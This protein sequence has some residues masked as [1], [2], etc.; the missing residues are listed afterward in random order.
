M[1][2]MHTYRPAKV[3][4]MFVDGLNYN[5]T[6]RAREL[7]SA[8]RKAHAARIAHR[9][10]KRHQID[11]HTAVPLSAEQ[12][13][14]AWKEEVSEDSQY[15]VTVRKKKC[16]GE[17][18]S[19]L[20]EG[21]SDPFDCLAIVVTPQINKVMT[22][23]R[24]VVIPSIF[25]TP[26]FRR[27]AKGVQSEPTVM[28]DSRV[29]SS[30]GAIRDWNLVKNSLQD[31][32]DAVSCIAGLLGLM[33]QLS[34]ES[35]GRNHL[36]AIKMQGRAAELLRHT[37]TRRN[38]DDLDSEMQLAWRV[39]WLFRGE[40][41]LGDVEAAR[42]HCKMLRHLTEHG[43]QHGTF[44]IQFLVSVLFNDVDL[45]A[46]TMR[47]TTLDLEIWFPSIMAPTWTALEPLLPPISL[48]FQDGLDPS[49]STEP[50]QTLFIRTRRL[51]A[52]GEQA[53]NEE[54]CTE[55]SRAD[56][57]FAWTVSHS[58]VDVGLFV[59]HYLDVSQLLASNNQDTELTSLGDFYTEASLNLAALC[60][61]RY[62]G[63]VAVVNGVDIRDVTPTIM[64]HLQSSMANALEMS[65]ADELSY[66]KNA[67]LWVL[68]VGALAQQRRA[69]QRGPFQRSWFQSKLVSM[70][71]EAGISTWK[72]LHKIVARFVYSDV[73]EPHG[74][75]W[76]ERCLTL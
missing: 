67:H 63:H 60:M 42:I 43:M 55:A 19:F 46:R 33:A 75:T 74:S 25:F 1:A 51:F 34:S 37:L 58:L 7:E 45:A 72:Q 4:L 61:T 18:F 50:L 26:Y 59:N 16:G 73:V 30:R 70:A 52:I 71:R 69:G 32:C 53:F 12:F 8:N 49:I 28:R 10:R 21:N 68:F 29:I 41:M 3:E 48:D 23:V 20:R 56:L 65:T 62:V 15:R 17:P 76:F 38:Q 54:D 39:F 35:A 9:R 47:R 36:A 13:V 27:C 24:D 66:Y 2:S 44:D 5:K 22:F 6:N 64:V 14:L 40:C 57:V 11:L 31:E